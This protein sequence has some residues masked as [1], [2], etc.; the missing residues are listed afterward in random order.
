[1]EGKKDSRWA[2][3][4][5]SAQDSFAPFLLFRAVILRYSPALHQAA[6]YEITLFLFVCCFFHPLSVQNIAFPRETDLPVV[7]RK[8]VSQCIRQRLLY[9]LQEASATSIL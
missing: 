3:K 6:D 4:S 8:R 1:M 9:L 5:R 2:R 7:R